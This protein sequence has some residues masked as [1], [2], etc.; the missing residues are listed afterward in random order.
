MMSMD[1]NNKK[2]GLGDYVSNPVADKPGK[3]MTGMVGNITKAD[4][5]K[6]VKSMAESAKSMEK[7]A[8]ENKESSDRMFDLSAELCNVYLNE[9]GTP[10]D[11]ADREGRKDLMDSIN[12]NTYMLEEFKKDLET[13]IKKLLSKIPAKVEAFLCDEHTKLLNSF[14]KNRVYYILTLVLIVII[15]VTAVIGGIVK[16]NEYADKAAEYEERCQ[17][18]DQRE[19]TNKDAAAFG[20]YM[21]QNNPNTF[22]RWKERQENND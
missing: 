21:R 20:I 5:D 9:D 16:A 7:S 14:Y 3:D 4:L 17:E 2:K 13:W 11:F 22:R 12:A 18:A 1:F 15:A 10:K 6:I 8:Q 19:K